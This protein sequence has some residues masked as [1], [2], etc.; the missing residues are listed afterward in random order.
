M[1]R[2]GVPDDLDGDLQD[3]PGDAS[4]GDLIPRRLVLRFGAAG[5][6][7]V[8]FGAFGGLAGPYL[9]QRGLLSPDGVLS[10]AGT[11]LADALFYKEA[12]PTS[13]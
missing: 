6:A 10:G 7:G 4:Q 8:A 1:S 3:D 9:A 2:D 12:F 11:A 13:R 5:A